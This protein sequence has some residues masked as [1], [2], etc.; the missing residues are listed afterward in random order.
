MSKLYFFP[1]NLAQLYK[2][3]LVTLVF[4]S[5]TGRWRRTQHASL[6]WP[7]RWRGG[8]VLSMA[9]C[10]GLQVGEVE[11][12]SAWQPAR[13]RGGDVLSMA[14]CSGLHVGEVETYSAWQSAVACTV[15]RWRRTQHG[16]LQWPARWRGGDVLSMAACSGLHVTCVAYSS[17][18][19]KLFH[20]TDVQQNSN[21]QLYV[22]RPV[23]WHRICHRVSQPASV[24]T[25]LLSCQR[26]CHRAGDPA[27]V[28]TILPRGQQTCQCA[29]DPVTVPAILRP[30]QRYY[31]RARDPATVPAILP[32]FQR[33]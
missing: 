3:K 31:H 27:I 13:W 24:S 23:A 26:S 20:F 1:T 10:S 4:A 12:H 9:A 28:S 11:T 7:A 2:K 6:Q 30:C 32:P 25:I 22:R 8:D 15:A 5:Q 29:S 14:D 16:S 33:S 19:T 18:L 17:V 21:L